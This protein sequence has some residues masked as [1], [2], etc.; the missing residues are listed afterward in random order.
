MDRTRT[1]NAKH[2]TR[3]RKMLRANKYAEIGRS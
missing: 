2:K 1:H 3:T